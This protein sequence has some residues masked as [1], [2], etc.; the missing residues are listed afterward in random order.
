MTTDM[1]TNIRA[2]RVRV[3]RSRG[4]LSGVLLIL[5]G[6]WAALIPFIGPYFNFAFTPSPNDAWHWT[7]GR[8]L[9]EVLPGATAALGGLLLLLSANRVT[10]SFGGWLG[11]AGGAWLI[12]APSLADPLNVSLGG[13]DPQSSSGVRTLEALLFFYA[14]GAAILFVA[15]LAL[16]RLSVHSVRDVK[17]AERR[18]AAEEAA[19]AEA[20]AAERGTQDRRTRDHAVD[21][22]H[23]RYGTDDSHDADRSRD[24]RRLDPAGDPNYADRDPQRHGGATDRPGAPGRHYE[25][26]QGVPPGQQGVPPGQQQP[27]PPQSGYNA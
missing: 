25:P 26:Q 4:A 1:N 24:P 22:P 18:A 17:A 11:A 15:A 21:E 3:A 20:A 27:P 10:A 12:V 6:A 14:I 19:A 5:L 23:S 16:G 9:F 7:S 13:P 2:S 8:G